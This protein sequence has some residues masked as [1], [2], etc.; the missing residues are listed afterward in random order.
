MPLKPRKASAST[1]ASSKGREAG[2]DDD[3][4]ENPVKTK[5]GAAKTA[6]KG[7]AKK[8]G[9]NTDE[10]PVRKGK[11]TK[12]PHV[13]QEVA[14][15]PVR[16]KT[17]E[18]E[19]APVAKRKINPRPI[20]KPLT[21]PVATEVE[22]QATGEH[23]LSEPLPPAPA[24]ST[25]RKIASAAPTLT[26][27]APTPASVETRADAVEPRRN[28]PRGLTPLDTRQA[29]TLSDARVVPS[30]RPTPLDTKPGL[31][32]SD[33][34]PRPPAAT[35]AHRSETPA[36]ILVPA[37]ETMPL[38]T[39][40]TLAPSDLPL[41]PGATGTR[42]AEVPAV[43]QPHSPPKRIAEEEA[44]VGTQRKRL[45]NNT[46]GATVLP[47]HESTSRHPSE[48]HDRPGPYPSSA[49]DAQYGYNYG[50]PPRFGGPYYHPGYAPP[51][52][53][54]RPP[55]YPNYSDHMSYSDQPRHHEDDDDRYAPYPMNAYHHS[56]PP[57]FFPPQHRGYMPPKQP[58]KPSH[59]K[60]D[61]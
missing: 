1:H 4:E 18:P 46:G 56:G 54:G 52:N 50:P 10:V 22:A 9:S 37:R 35:S 53:W 8:G 20:K 61:A 21:G 30:H 48:D 44:E 45:R 2:S 27:R 38:E 39:T 55:G 57:H 7:K 58:S 60:D 19:L 33:A 40:A 13:A 43:V 28:A 26:R 3:K 17:K 12:E 23:E 29:P 32:P 11:A 36:I 31:A 24:D 59:Y 5:G 49:W 14:Q 34:R 41:P 51:P 16:A 47:A 42:H 25:S 15:E 6:S